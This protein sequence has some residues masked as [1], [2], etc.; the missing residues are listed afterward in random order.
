MKKIITIVITLAVLVCC[1]AHALA[2]DAYL[3]ATPYDFTGECPEQVLSFCSQGGAA[4]YEWLGV[5]TVTYF[6][7]SCD[8][9]S[10]ESYAA[11]I[12]GISD[13]MVGDTEK[14]MII[15]ADAEI[16]QIYVL[17][18]DEYA[19]Y[20][21]QEEAERCI[22]ESNITQQ[23]NIY[24][25]VVAF[26]K[27]MA[28]ALLEKENEIE[29]ARAAGAAEEAGDPFFEELSAQPVYIRSTSLIVQSEEYKA[30]YPDLLQATIVNNSEDD[31]KDVTVAFMAWDSNNLPVLLKVQLDFGA[32]AYV[33]K[34]TYTGVNMVPGSTYGEHAGLKLDESVKDV[35]TVK[36]IVVSYDTFEGE[37]W[38]NPLYD[39]F[40]EM[41]EGKKLLQ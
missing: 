21:S 32:A 15:L 2:E 10:L 29:A 25:G 36:A 1:M 13:R 3:G 41:Y 8:G 11:I 23:G 24:D 18:G 31:V 35:A 27:A 19:Q 38:E 14:D 22:E 20:F 17:L 16:N 7:P 40:V 6:V 34:G 5:R 9:L 12:K 37:T 30:L 26:Y 39:E 33:K 28:Q 4:I